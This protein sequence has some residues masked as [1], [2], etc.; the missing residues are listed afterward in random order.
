MFKPSSFLKYI[1]ISCIYYYNGS[2]A[3]LLLL[4]DRRKETF[5]SVFFKVG[6]I[7]N[8]IENPVGLY[9]SW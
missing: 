6:V 9:E 3:P 7:S 2:G 5:F 8:H 4:I 1:K